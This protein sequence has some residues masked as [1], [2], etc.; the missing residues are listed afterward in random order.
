MS[1][2]TTWIQAPQKAGKEVQA[3]KHSTGHSEAGKSEF[4]VILGYKV[5]LRQLGNM[6]SCLKKLSK[7][8]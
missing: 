3:C 8:L 6:R 1:K 7:I 4:K 2:N 5:S